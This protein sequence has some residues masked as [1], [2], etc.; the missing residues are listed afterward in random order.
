MSAK[1]P[2]IAFD[3]STAHF[4]LINLLKN[5]WKGIYEKK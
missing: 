5:N 2:V 3:H 1:I 4:C